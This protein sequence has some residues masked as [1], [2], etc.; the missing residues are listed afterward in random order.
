MTTAEPS[1]LTDPEDVRVAA[2]EEPRE[3]QGAGVGDDVRYALRLAKQYFAADPAPGV[4][5]LG[6][7]IGLRALGSYAA[8]QASLAAAAVTTAIA[9]GQGGKVTP[10]LT[11]AALFLLGALALTIITEWIE[12]VL[13]IRTRTV[14][15][16]T[17]AGRWLG[18]DRYYHLERGPALDHPEQRIQEDIFIFVQQM[19][20]I[21]PGIIGAL[22]PVVIYSGQLWKQSPPLSLAGI[23]LPI[24]LDGF[25]V[26]A[27]I[28]FAVAWTFVTHWAGKSL[29]QTEITRQGLEAQFRQE[30]GAVRENSEAI[31][32]QKGAAFEGARIAGTYGL[33][34]QNWRHYTLAN[35]KVTFITNLPN[36]VFLLAPMAIC[37]PFVLKG[38]MKIGDIQFVSGAMTVMFGSVG[39]LIG[40]YRALAILRSAIARLRYFNVLLDGLSTEGGISVE[41]T[42]GPGYAARGLTLALPNGTPLV[43]IG[44]L[45]VNK[46]DR[47]LIKGPS[48]AGKSTFLRALAGLW[49]HGRGS[50]SAPAEAR[51][52][53]MPQR[54]YMPD[55]SLASLM[56]YPSD[57]A[58]VPDEVYRELLGSL[59]LGQL[60]GR[61]HEYAAW[62]RILSPGEQ[63]RIAAARAVLN[64][65]DFLFVDE[66]TSALDM[67]SEA[68]FYTLLGERLPKAAIISVAHRPTVE[69]YH[70]RI[71]DFSG[72]K[73]TET[74]RDPSAAAAT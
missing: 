49:P 68:T 20:S 55:G 72:G 35:L 66:A 14:L 25:L 67:R 41:Q 33:I 63:Q 48:G 74:R 1:S 65:P 38:Q 32:F 43:D 36:S 30:M 42:S 12:Y 73:A 37:A 59:G 46:G 8:M 22:F 53:F 45:T 6:G 70:D 31:A 7:K 23:G 50:V 71:V 61:L 19:L 34:K 15:T 60:A 3:S 10:L 28:G 27:T 4:G 9:A 64:S 11:S 69:E 29:T 52:Y 58:E 5:L 54:A 39:V 40:T 57:P 47:L 26:Y 51:V 21:L 17:L 2:G 62:K 24:V 16:D 18:Q 13:R 56:S 44:D